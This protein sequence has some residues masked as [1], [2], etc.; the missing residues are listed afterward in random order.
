MLEISLL[1]QFKNGHLFEDVA[2]MSM[3]EAEKQLEIIIAD[4]LDSI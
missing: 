2:H 3:I 4:F 1:K